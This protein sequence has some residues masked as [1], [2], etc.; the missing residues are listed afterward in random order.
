VSTAVVTGAARGIGAA[1][2]KRL[3]RDGYSVIGIDV[4][5]ADSPH[6]E[7]HLCDVSDEK[8][9]ATVFGT[10][11]Q[12]GDKIDVLVNVA[13]TVLVRPFLD[14]TW[15]DY[16][17]TL[18]VNLGGTILACRYAVQLMK[19]GSA[20][21]NI[22]SISGHI[23][24]PQHAIYAASKGAVLALTRG[25]AWE[26]APLGIRVNTV[27]PGSV[28]TEMLRSDI[29]TEAARMGRRYEE[30]KAEREAEQALGRWARPEE[31]ANAIAF[32]A[33]DASSFITGS[34]LLVD[35]GWVAK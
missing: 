18:D 26:L 11:A 19:P 22:A 14:S 24:Q 30:V 33:D 2:V 32:L 13:G 12:R 3:V 31:I 8:A 27:S 4:L 9:M 10:L 29:R 21:V 25:L 1:T 17:R 7:H 35:S 15:A 20:I 6:G 34:D 5:P 28:D 16:R 23:G